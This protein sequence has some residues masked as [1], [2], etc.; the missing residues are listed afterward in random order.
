M[1]HVLKSIDESRRFIATGTAPVGDTVGSGGRSTHITRSTEQLV[2][3][4]RVRGKVPD[5]SAAKSTNNFAS[6]A[7]I[8]GS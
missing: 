1:V 5:T 6:I 4:R 3:E 8:I 7:E 2:G